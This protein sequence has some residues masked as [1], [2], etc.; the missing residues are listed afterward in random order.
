MRLQAMPPPLNC[1]NPGTPPPVSNVPDYSDG[2]W[3]TK[4]PLQIDTITRALACDA[5]RV[6]TLSFG[7]AQEDHMFDWLPNI[8][9]HF[10]NIAHGSQATNGGDWTMHFTIRTWMAQQ[11]A[12]LAQGL[13]AIPEGPGTALD[14]T[15]IVWLSELG[16][17]TPK[18]DPSNQ[19]HL[20][21]DYGGSTASAIIGGGGGAI[22]CGQVLDVG[23]R[24]YCDLLLTLVHAMGYTDVTTVGKSST[25][26]I[27]ALLK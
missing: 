26:P 5:T 11:V 17:E 23:G 21:G 1:A 19:A 3:P 6:A 4:A 14:N 24:D 15:A 2:D 12:R 20:R 18:S 25:G 7:I 27:A 22:D 8:T 10:H 16:Y 13:A 9:D